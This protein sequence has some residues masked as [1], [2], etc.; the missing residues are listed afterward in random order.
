V[1]SRGATGLTCKC[2]RPRAN[3]LRRDRFEE[4]VGAE[5]RAGP[6]QVQLIGLD[7]LGTHA[8]CG[9][10]QLQVFLGRREQGQGD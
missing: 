7:G 2:A 9:G 8:A 6:L 5:V 3:L 10:L 1:G 4:S